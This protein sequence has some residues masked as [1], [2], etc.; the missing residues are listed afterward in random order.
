VAEQDF[1]H[2]IG[3][4]KT[5]QID[6]KSKEETLLLLQVHICSRLRQ[7]S[8][9]TEWRGGEDEDTNLCFGTEPLLEASMRVSLVVSMSERVDVCEPVPTVTCQSED[10]YILGRARGAVV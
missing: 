8:G 9:E 3:N 1:N 7:S 5:T 6:V 4:D 2:G 10:R